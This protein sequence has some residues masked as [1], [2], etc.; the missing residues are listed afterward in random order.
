MSTKSD[1]LSSFELFR[2]NGGGIEA[3]FTDRIP[4][5]VVEVLTDCEKNPILVKFCASY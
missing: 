3:W 5:T 1:L 4:E 2:G